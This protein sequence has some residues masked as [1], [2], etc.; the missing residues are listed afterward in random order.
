[1][2]AAL[3][4]ADAAHAGRT[5]SE[6]KKINWKDGISAVYCI[7]KYG[8]FAPSQPLPEGGDEGWWDI[9]TNQ[10]ELRP[11]DGAIHHGWARWWD[12]DGGGLADMGQHYLDPVQYMLNKDDTSPIKVEVDAPQQ[13]PDARLVLVCALRP[14][15]RLLGGDQP[16]PGDPRRACTPGSGRHRGRSGGRDGGG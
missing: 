2:I 14:G 13:H 16:Q 8:L 6:G 1:M 10:A 15:G 5:Y 7:L 12:Y 9:W 3:L 11:Y 4:S